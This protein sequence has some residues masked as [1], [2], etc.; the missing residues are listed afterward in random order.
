MKYV[1]KDTILMHVLERES[2]VSV[3]ILGGNLK[4]HI[5]NYL[6]FVLMKYMY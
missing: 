6:D 5:F 2:S 1:R 3:K 4:V